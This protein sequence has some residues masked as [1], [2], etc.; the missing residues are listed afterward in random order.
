[1][2]TAGVVAGVVLAL[3][4]AAPG[5]ADGLVRQVPKA[6][7]W[8]R[9]YCTEEFDDGVKRDRYVTLSC[10]GGEKAG[11]EPS[12]W[13]ELKYQTGPARPGA[14]WKFLIPEKHLG[15][16]GDPLA[17]A[18]K[19]WFRGADADAA[20]EARP[21]APNLPRL[22]LVLPPD[23]GAV[24][25]VR[26]EQHFDWQ[27]GRLTS[28]TVLEAARHAHPAETV[29]TRYRL[30]VHDGVPFGVAG[31]RVEID[32]TLGYKGTVRYWLTDMGAGATS[33]L[34]DAK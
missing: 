6:G 18:V 19:A 20:P 16:G 2:R 14:V 29:R 15:P 3:G 1:M 17:H 5:R 23:L 31:A 12:L 13:I 30:A 21:V 7:A 32:S 8:A 22:Y 11:G 9:F 26:E 25:R 10:V 33:D 34:P 24:K 4:L 28:E 27:K